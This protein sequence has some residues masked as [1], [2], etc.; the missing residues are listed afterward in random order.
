M[1]STPVLAAVLVGL[2]TVALRGSFLVFADRL[3]ELP[4]R[5]HEV[6]RMIP[7]AALAALVTPALLRPDGQL[8]PLG[9][10]ALAGL[11]ALVVAW[12]TRSL[13]ATILVGMAAVV[14]LQLLLS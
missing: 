13:L 10:E 14:G 3:A 6:L 9:P 12:R 4:P 1:T 11:A 7:P 5:V 8:A 2:G